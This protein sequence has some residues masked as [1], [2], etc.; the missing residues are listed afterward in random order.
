M[1]K[2]SA[3]RAQLARERD[4]RVTLSRGP[5]DNPAE[6]VVRLVRVGDRISSPD[7][8]GWDGSVVVE[9]LTTDGVHPDYVVRA[10]R[11]DGTS[12][13]FTFSEV[14]VQSRRRS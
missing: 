6:A 5:M 2:Q 10:V 9:I 7:F 12:G 11:R 14:S 1:T 13:L 4:E 3:W 8:P